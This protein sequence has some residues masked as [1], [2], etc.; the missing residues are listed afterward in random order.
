MT[1]ARH[2]SSVSLENIAGVNLI[3][4]VVQ[5]GV[6]PISN[7]RLTLLL[8]FCQIIHH[9]TTEERLAIGNRWLIDDHLGTLGLDALHDALDGA[10]AEVIAVGLHGEAVDTNDAT[11]LAMGIPLAAGFVIAS[12]TQYLVGNEVLTSAITLDN[13]GHHLLGHIGI[14]GQQLLGVLRQAVAAIAKRGVVVM[15]ADAIPATAIF[16]IISH[17]NLFV[18]FNVHTENT[19]ITERCHHR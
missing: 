11:L 18:I 12:L 4:Y 15:G 8:E 2:L 14:V 6:V 1:S 13:G 9:L 16:A 10:L 19:E 17:S 3:F 7:N 5:A